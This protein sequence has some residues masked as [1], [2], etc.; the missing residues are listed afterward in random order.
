MMKSLYGR[1]KPIF[2]LSKTVGSGDSTTSVV[3]MQGFTSCCFSFLAGVFALTS[4][5]KA[6]L[7]MLESDD[8]TTY[9]TVAAADIEGMETASVFRAWDLSASDASTITNLFYRGTKRYV[10]GVIVESGTVALPMGCV[11]ICG[12]SHNKPSVD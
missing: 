6:V 1:V 5:N 2:A 10:K 4:T 8:N 3:D 12:D 9:G 11:V 7:T